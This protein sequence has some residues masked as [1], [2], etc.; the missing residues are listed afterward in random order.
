MLK[1]AYGVAPSP[2]P[3][4]VCSVVKTCASAGGPVQTINISTIASADPMGLA[5]ACSLV[6]KFQI[7]PHPGG[8]MMICPFR[9]P[10]RRRASGRILHHRLP[11]QKPSHECPYARSEERRVGKE[12]RS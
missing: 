10:A 1:P 11:K 4:K 2:P 7:R 12:C 6:P 9:E 8:N 5:A 3:V